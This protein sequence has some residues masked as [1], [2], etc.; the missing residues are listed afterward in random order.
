M[1]AASR[2]GWWRKVFT[3]V[4]QEGMNNKWFQER[5]LFFVARKLFFV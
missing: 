4:C 1:T 3:L 2:K 5:G